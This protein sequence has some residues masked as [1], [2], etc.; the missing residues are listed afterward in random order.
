M[1]NFMISIYNW[2]VF[3]KRNGLFLLRGTSWMF[4]VQFRFIRKCEPNEYVGCFLAFLYDTVRLAVFMW[5][6]P[7]EM[8]DYSFGGSCLSGC[9]SFVMS[10]ALWRVSGVMMCQ[11][12]YDVPVAL[13]CVSGVMMCQWRYDVSVAVWC[14]SGVMM[15]QWPYDVSVALWCV[16]GVM[17]CQ[18]R[19]DVSVAVWCVS[20]VMMWLGQM[21]LLDQDQYTVANWRHVSLQ[22]NVRLILPYTGNTRRDFCEAKKW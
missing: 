20:G 9:T 1:T 6:E 12:R 4:Q 7:C 22:Q 13:W 21:S 18:W 8:L 16:S 11:W 14:V 5:V 3:R 19:Y 17:M 15:C 2:L 10:V